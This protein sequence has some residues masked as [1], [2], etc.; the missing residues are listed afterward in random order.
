[1]FINKKIFIL[2]SLSYTTQ[3]SSLGAIQLR[4]HCDITEHL[5]IHKFSKT[6]NYLVEVKKEDTYKMLSLELARRIG[7]GDYL[8]NVISNKDGSDYLNRTKELSLCKKKVTL[9]DLG[10]KNKDQLSIYYQSSG[11]DWPTSMYIWDIVKRDWKKQKGWSLESIDVIDSTLIL[12]FMD[13]KNPKVPQEN[14]PKAYMLEAMYFDLKTTQYTFKDIPDVLCGKSLELTID[15]NSQQG[16]DINVVYAFIGQYAQ[17]YV[18]FELSRMMLSFYTEYVLHSVKIDCIPPPKYNSCYINPLSFLVDKVIKKKKEEINN[19]MTQE[20]TDYP[21]GE[22]PSPGSAEQKS[23]PPPTGNNTTSIKA[24]NN[25]AQ[26]DH[27][28]HNGGNIQKRSIMYQ[29]MAAI[30]TI[31]GIVFYLIQLKAG[32]K[33]RDMNH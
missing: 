29:S 4:V 1:M 20:N 3:A 7:I 24:E 32:E 12:L 10:I 6:G 8:F 2:L 18:P 17:E 9:E 28:S 21:D 22:I 13:T 23:L 16:K 26:L 33:H 5:A 30:I 19:S 11:K 15:S 31:V 14:N 25:H 27:A